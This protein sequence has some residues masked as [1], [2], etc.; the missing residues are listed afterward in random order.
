MARDKAVLAD[1][2]MRVASSGF[3]QKPTLRTG[4]ASRFGAPIVRSPIK[5]QSVT[6]F[7]VCNVPDIETQTPVDIMVSVVTR[8]TSPTPPAHSTFLRSKHAGQQEFSVLMVPRKYEKGVD[9]SLQTDERFLRG[10]S[11]LKPVSSIPVARYVG[12]RSGYNYSKSKDGGS[13]SDYS[14]MLM[15]DCLKSSM[16][17]SLNL[18]RSRTRFVSF[19]FVQPQ[20]ESFERCRDNKTTSTE[21][22][23]T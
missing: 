20:Q 18:T 3:G 1:K 2:R 17:N 6:V 22:D 7:G 5:E 14:G 19:R 11:S 23:K 4:S 12:N 8:G 13:T 15:F 9:V 10:M 21:L 16:H